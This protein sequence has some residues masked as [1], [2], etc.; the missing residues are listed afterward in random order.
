VQHGAGRCDAESGLV[1]QCGS[2]HIHLP[3]NQSIH[4]A[5]SGASRSSAAL[6]C[7]HETL[8][9]KHMGTKGDLF[10]KNHPA[11]ILHWAPRESLSLGIHN[12]QAMYTPTN[13]CRNFV[14]KWCQGSGAVRVVCAQCIQDNTTQHWKTRTKFTKSRNPLERVLFLETPFWLTLGSQSDSPW[15][16]VSWRYLKSRWKKA[17]YYCAPLEC[18]PAVIGLL[19]VWRQNTPKQH[20]CSSQTLWLPQVFRERN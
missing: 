12:A 19:A 4:C 2:V 16:S 8:F 13:A 18:V 17:T 6:R 9:N 14:T 3:R 10:V 7:H 20:T 15:Y 11:Q 1:S 5:R